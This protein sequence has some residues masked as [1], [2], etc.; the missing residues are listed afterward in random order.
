MFLEEWRIIKNSNYEV[1][2]AGRVRSMSRSFIKSDNT[3]CTIS[4]KILKPAKDNKGY[5]RVGIMI[6][7]KLITKKIHRLV[8]IF[9]IENLKNKPQVNHIDGNK[10]NNQANNLE[11]STGSENMKHAY[12]IGLQKPLYFKG[13]RRSYNGE[14]N[15]FSKLTGDQVLEIR[16]KFIPRIYTRSILALEYGVKEACIKDILLKKSWKHL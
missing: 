13:K 2:S 7:G 4:S 1:S 6:E 11:W 8:A 10:E 9:F 5:F 15:H 14:G 16:S 3:R 12:S